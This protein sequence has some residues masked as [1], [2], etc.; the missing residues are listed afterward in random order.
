VSKNAVVGTRG[1]TKL[2]GKYRFG[3]LLWE[4]DIKVVLI[5]V[6]Y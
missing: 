4:G 2:L 1:A 3:T 6:G 5:E